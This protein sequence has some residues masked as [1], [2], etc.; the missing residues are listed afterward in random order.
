[1]AVLLLALAHWR[2]LA[3]GLAAGALAILAWRW[4]EAAAR[5]GYDTCRQEIA[6]A[7]LRRTKDATDADEISRRC[8]AD[9]ECRL[10]RD[11]YRRD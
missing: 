8:A 3:L 9:P 4:D 11:P 1:M 6:A 10:R 2:P 5:R 7:E